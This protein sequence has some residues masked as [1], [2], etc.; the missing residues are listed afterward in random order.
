MQQLSLVLATSK[1]QNLKTMQQLLLALCC[2]YAFS[3][4]PKPDPISP[5]PQELLTK[6][7][8]VSLKIT[9]SADSSSTL[10]VGEQFMEFQSATLHA[11]LQMTEGFMQPCP[12]TAVD[13]GPVPELLYAYEDHPFSCHEALYE[14]V[15][16]Y[17]SCSD[18]HL[19][20]L[21]E[22]VYDYL[23]RELW[24]VPAGEEIGLD[25]QEVTGK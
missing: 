3:A 17:A 13:F 8:P 10:R 21:Q 18:C 1:L 19:E 14:T 16:L 5:A 9:Y 7:G 15:D 23:M 24:L 12:R 6:Y 25:T 4:P 11:I 2:L 22:V 20:E